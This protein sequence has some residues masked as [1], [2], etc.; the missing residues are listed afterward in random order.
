MKSTLVRSAAAIVLCVVSTFAFAQQNAIPDAPHLVVFGEATASAVPD[1]FEL[2]LE[3]QSTHADAGLA[4]RRVT[5]LFDGIL[6]RSRANDVADQDITATALAIGQEQ[7]WVPESN[8]HEF[9]GTRVSRQVS[10]RFADAAQLSAFLDGL[11]TSEELGVQAVQARVSDEQELT[12]Q[13]KARA[14]QHTRDKADAMAEAMGATVS[15][16]YGV[17]DVAPRFD[18]GVVEGDWP[19]RLRWDS[20]KRAFAMVGMGGDADHQYVPGEA[21]YPGEI[22]FT[23]RV[24]AVFLIEQD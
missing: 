24:Y 10:I 23:E 16:L 1:R 8:T 18:Y 7:R 17:S 22:E 13:L 2:N 4:R 14:L 21:F 15:G 12:R 5:E 3:L 19:V 11:V 9:L 6:Q 20:Q